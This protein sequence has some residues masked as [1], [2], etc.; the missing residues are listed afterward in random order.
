VK[1]NKS[2]VLLLRFNALGDLI[3]ST[4]LLEPLRRH[5]AEVHL[6]TEPVYA[7]LLGRDPRWTRIWT[8][9]RR[10]SRSEWTAILRELKTSGP[11]AWVLD[12]Q[13]KPRTRWLARQLPAHRR[14]SVRRWSLY[15]RWAV[16]R[17]HLTHDWMLDRALLQAVGEPA[18]PAVP[19]LQGTYPF[20]PHA[21]KGALVVGV[22]AARPLRVWPRPHVRALVIRLARTFPVA[23]V[24]DAADASRFAG[25][26][27]P[28]GVWNGLGRTTLPELAGLLQHA[29]MF[30]GM[31]SGPAHL[32]AALGVPTVVLYGPTHPALGMRPRGPAPVWALGVAL[33][34][35][36]CT[37]HGEGRCPLGTHRCMTALT[38]ERVAAFVERLVDAD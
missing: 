22:G 20:P 8:I 9:S 11:W 30:V 32:A 17:K 27:W 15:R 7:D 16:R 4:V 3:Q 13:G 21:P 26:V 24:G 10:S 2:R 14:T 19:T 31:D 37:L 18:A 36:P 25:M 23:L 29:R 1:A 34:C 38:P 28:R 35:R 5:F 6:L 12:L 33:P